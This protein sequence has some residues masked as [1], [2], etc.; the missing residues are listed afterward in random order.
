MNLVVLRSSESP[1]E[2]TKSRSLSTEQTFRG[3]TNGSSTPHLTFPTAPALTLRSTSAAKY[4]HPLSQWI[5]IPHLGCRDP[6]PGPRLPLVARTGPGRTPSSRRSSLS[7]GVLIHPRGCLRMRSQPPKSYLNRITSEMPSSSP[8]RR[9][10]FH[11]IGCRSYIPQQLSKPSAK[12]FA[13]MP[14]KAI[15]VLP[16]ARRTDVFNVA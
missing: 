10:R 16:G 12:M 1:G 2:A 13:A 11:R 5:I 3:E 4:H 14:E 7:D 9:P 15:R 8:C 6:F